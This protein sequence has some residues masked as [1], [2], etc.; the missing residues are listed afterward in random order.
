MISFWNQNF[1]IV[2]YYN[3]AIND[4]A[5]AMCQVLSMYINPSKQG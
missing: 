5:P 1:I 4:V 2:F 3:I